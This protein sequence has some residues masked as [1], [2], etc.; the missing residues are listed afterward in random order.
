MS[1]TLKRRLESELGADAVISDPD[2][3]LSYQR[4]WT[5][6]WHG[7]AVLAVRPAS[8]EG[9]AAAL[10]ACAAAEVGLVVQGGNTGLVGGATP[11][12][13]VVLDTGALRELGEVDRRSAQ[14][15]VGAGVKLEEAQQLARAAGFDLGVDLA[16]RGQATIGGMVATNAG[17]AM[18]L[19]YGTMRA[20]VA[21]LEAALGDGRIV[22]RLSGLP[23]DNA[24]YD[25]AALLIGSEGTL[26]VVTKV[27]LALVRKP[28]RRVTG[29]LGME[30]LEEA[31]DLVAAMRDRLSGE[32]EAAECF[33]RAGLEM[34]CERLGLRDPLDD[35][36]PFYLLIQVASDAQPT[37]LLAKALPDRY[38][39]AMAIAEDAAR[40]EALW[41][42]R[43]SLNEAATARGVSRKYDVSIPLAALPRFAAAVAAE[44]GRYDDAA[45]ISTYGH[46]GDGNLH[47]SV[48]ELKRDGRDLDRRVANLVDR[49]GGTISAEHGIGRAKRE[50][51]EPSR[52]RAEIEAMEAIKRAL[53]PAGV[54]ARG[55][56]FASQKTVL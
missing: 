42:Y 24:G 40:R 30:T 33:D 15:T 48:F 16:A 25:L 26:G 41:T 1:L 22:S 7:T 43:E 17:G 32:L 27:R 29:L 8:T 37:E 46:L 18:A 12:N 10:I 6:S 2:L 47:I 23:K 5:G 21:G 39:E 35:P 55:R 56:V 49:H 34:A 4:D 54:L 19:R 13:E 45:F 9:V 11:D 3:L 50:I 44:V 51:L 53:D 14:V 36:S 52:S 31:V 20:N 28:A 38:L